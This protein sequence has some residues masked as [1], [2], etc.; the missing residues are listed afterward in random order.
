MIVQLRLHGDKLDTMTFDKPSTLPLNIATV[1]KPPKEQV[2]THITF[3]H[4]NTQAFDTNILLI[5]RNFS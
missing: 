2:I 1:D 3:S 4:K 5:N